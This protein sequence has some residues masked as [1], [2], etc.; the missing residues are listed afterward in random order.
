MLEPEFMGRIQWTLRKGQVYLEEGKLGVQ[1]VK[2][3]KIRNT[4]TLRPMEEGI[5][6][7]LT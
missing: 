1:N 5:Y 7:E 6:T 3:Q 2:E 4:L